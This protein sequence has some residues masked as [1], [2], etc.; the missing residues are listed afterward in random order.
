MRVVRG[1]DVE[2]MEAGAFDALASTFTR[3]AVDVGTGD[4]RLP[5]RMARDDPST[6]WVGID[7]TPENM[8][9]TASRSA[10]K[11]TKGGAPN[12][13]LVVADAASPPSEL[14]GRADELHVI[15]PWGRLMEGIVLGDRDVLAGLRA[16]CR[17]GAPLDIVLN[18]GVWDVSTPRHV[19]PLPEVTEEHVDKV[20]AAALETEGFTLVR[21][22]PMSSQ[23]VRALRSTWAG[24][25]THGGGGRF[26]RIEGVA[27]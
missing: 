18:V 1:R 23:D 20:L 12:L 9:A 6:L 22:E 14:A 4:G 13:V 24:R 5:Y 16:L 8:T 26:L 21:R 19:E 15:L 10:R 11:P 2:V 27:V 3:I 7:A 25:L 17:T